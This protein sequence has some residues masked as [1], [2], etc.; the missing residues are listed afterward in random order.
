LLSYLK[1]N[2][3]DFVSG[4]FLGQRIGIT[5]SAIWKHIMKLREEGYD[6][7][8]SCRKG[9]CLLSRSEM[10]L[11]REIVEG[12]DT[13]IFGRK[14]IIHFRETDSTNARARELAEQGAPEGTL[15]V[16][17]RQTRGRGR[18]G[19]FW[20]SPPGAGIYT[21]L[22]LRPAMRPN[23]APKI[24]FLTAVSAAE[25]LIRLTK[26]DVRIKWPNDL[27]V[28]GKKIAG[29]LTEISAGREGLEYAVVGIGI[30]V[31]TPAFPDEIGRKATS[32]LIET[33]E[34]FPRTRLLKEYLRQQE[35]YFGRLR[36]YGFAPIL[37]RWKELT[38]TIGRQIRVEMM[39]KTY[40]GRV[41]GIDPEGVLIL[42]DREGVFH[43]IFS[44]DVA[45]L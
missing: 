23:D 2:R 44:G 5:R 4:E 27:L 32:V 29:I 3:G 7:R 9:Y 28:N 1:E 21:S 11:P 19:R 22:I 17:E 36:T 26:L 16:S 20:F 33:G 6:I 40:V 10:L 25:A 38:D 34:R 30:N 13:E 37:N 39:D 31:N 42:K 24:T 43:R 41:E 35:R 12:L 18:K 14:E 45:L 8:S 15:V